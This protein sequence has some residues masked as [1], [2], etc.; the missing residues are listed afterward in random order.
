VPYR[1]VAGIAIEG[2]EFD[3]LV[4]A[5]LSLREL[6]TW[7]DF[8]AASG[9]L[10]VGPGRMV[11][12]SFYAAGLTPGQTVRVTRGERSVELRLAGTLDNTPADAGLL[13]DPSDLDKLG[14]GPEPTA[15]LADVAESG[16]AARTAAVKALQ[17]ITGPELTILVLADQRD[18][19]TSEL[20]NVILVMLSLVGLT[21]IVAVVGVGTTTAL[22]VV[23]RVREAGLLRAVGLS[24]SGL[25]GM[26]T[27]EAGLYGFIGAVLGLGLAIP[28][29]W[30]AVATLGADVPIEFPAGDLALVVVVLT[31]ATATAGLWPAYRAARISPVAAL[32]ADSH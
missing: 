7:D 28:Y 21:V 4:A 12:L 13:L 11:A 19:M 14:I 25:R 1:R 2:L 18:D 26:L 10:D 20:N 3:S 31:V 24:R 27:L 5:D 30:L 9:D 17:A 23:E 16:A 22:S 32:G 15:M 29:S 8:G 6:S